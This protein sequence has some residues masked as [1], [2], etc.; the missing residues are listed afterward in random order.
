MKIIIAFLAINFSIQAS[1]FDTAIGTVYKKKGNWFLSAQD[2]KVEN[3][4]LRKTQLKLLNISKEQQSV[5]KEQTFKKIT[6]KLV[7]CDSKFKC[8]SV[9]TISSTLYKPIKKVP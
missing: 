9:K 4:E 6:G 2:G 8:F 7:K 1:E 3:K 5:L